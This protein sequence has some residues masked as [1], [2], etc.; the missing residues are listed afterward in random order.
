MRRSLSAA[1]VFSAKVFDGKKTAMTPAARERLRVRIPLLVTS[2]AAWL[3]LLVEHHGVALVDHCAA[4]IEKAALLSL[5]GFIAGNPLT[6]PVGGWALM[7]AAMMAPLLRAPLSHVRDRSLATRRA[8]ATL[9]FAT[10]YLTVWMAAGGMLVV[11]ATAIQALS[12]NSYLVLLLGANAAIVW[13]FTPLKQRCLNRCHVQVEIG[14]FG[15]AADTRIFHSGLQHGMWCVGSCWLLMLMPLLLPQR[16]L[17]TMAVVGL[18]MY[19]ERLES[20]TIPRWRWRA[21]GK[22]LRMVIAQA[23]IQLVRSRKP[24]LNGI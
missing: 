20:P 3:L 4:P 5:K 7:I 13:Q 16:H 23:R 15:T 19:A 12:P 24:I 17:T 21:P 22:A 18:W 14:A 1:S 6:S 2:A 11:M 10:A 8:R 9:S